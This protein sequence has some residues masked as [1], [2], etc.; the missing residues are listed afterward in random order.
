MTMHK[1]LDAFVAGRPR[2]KGSLDAQQRRGGRGGTRMVENV[3]GSV[4][5]RIM[6]AAV[7]AKAWRTPD[8]VPREP[9]EGVAIRVA[10]TFYLP[11]PRPE[12]LYAARS[13]DVDKLTRNLLDALAVD[14]TGMGKGAGVIAND[15]QVVGIVIEKAYAADA[16]GPHGHGKGLRPQGVHVQV[17]MVT[18]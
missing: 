18:P 13:G 5:W 16:S 9:L 12:S 7:F 8:G 11:C 2:T 15:A 10:A 6:M 1:V 3:A 4:T 14:E 17:W